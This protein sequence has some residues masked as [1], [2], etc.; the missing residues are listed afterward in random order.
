MRS[1]S[2]SIVFCCIFLC[3]SIVIAQD[4]TA[5]VEIPP[6]T[7]TTPFP[8]TSSDVSPPQQDTLPIPISFTIRGGSALGAYEAGYMYMLTETIKRNRKLF[9]PEIVT[10]ASA[11]T[12]NAILTILALGTAPQDDPQK[13]L[14]YKVWTKLGYEELLDAT[15]DRTPPGA[16]SSRSLLWRLSEMIKEEW[17]KGL[18][19]DFSITVGASTTRLLATNLEITK[20]LSIP[21]QISQFVFRVEGQGPGKPPRLTNQLWAKPSLDQLILPFSEAGNNNGQNYEVM[22]KVAFASCGIPVV[23]PPQWVDYCTVKVNENIDQRTSLEC[24][25]GLNTVADRF[26][27]GGVVDN[28]PI[29]LAY[30]LSLNKPEKE[31]LGKIE[32][33]LSS[34]ETTSKTDKTLFLYLDPDHPSYPSNDKHSSHQILDK[35]TPRYTMKGTE[36]F[37][38][39]PKFLSGFVGSVNASELYSLLQGDPQIRKRVKLTN[40]FY[41]P[42]ASVWDGK[43]GFMDKE[44]MKYDFYL[45]MHDAQNFIQK[46]VT[47]YL[48]TISKFKD[49]NNGKINLLSD[50]LAK[51]NNKSWKPYRCMRA[52]F[53][54]EG[55]KEQSC[56]IKQEI[57]HDAPSEKERIATSPPNVRDFKILMQTTVDRL[58]NHCSLLRGKGRK[59]EVISSGHKLC[60]KAYNQDPPEHV[61]GVKTFSGKGKEDDEWYKCIAKRKAKHR[62]EKNRAVRFCNHH[63]DNES[64]YEYVLRL[65]ARYEFGFKDLDLD[66]GRGDRAAAKIQSVFWKLLTD[67]DD[68]HNSTVQTLGKPAVTFLT[69][70]PPRNIFYVMVGKVLMFGWS[71]SPSGW[72]RFN[73]NILQIK[74]AQT[75]LSS[76]NAVA[77]FSSAVGIEYQPPWLS[78]P[79]F[80]TTAGARLG[81]QF[82]TKINFDRNS[83]NNEVGDKTLNCSSPIIQ[84]FLSASIFSRIRFEIGLEFF[85][86]IRD[87]KYTMS[88]FEYTYI[89]TVGY[90]FLPSF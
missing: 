62:K 41:Q 45:G 71:R 90:Q 18:S 58:Y 4:A 26:V 35:P 68:P 31:D 83:C 29:N 63:R 50:N 32:Q 88:E 44:F 30:L 28:S 74:G 7:S 60:L 89:A 61:P 1:G 70:V 42:I 78:F 81:Y 37:K 25:Y 43:F 47:N 77:T 82:S 38:T 48:E 20:D 56:N 23:F 53:D 59:E 36:L 5:E 86:S 51:T 21:N 22:M 13:S 64:Q 40:N 6:S 24:K 9:K 69:Y 33:R 87:W 16:L 8:K 27:D 14:Y 66:P 3:H 73:W 85:P 76:E 84:G 34:I 10:G 57:S 80:Q 79:L 49:I 19:N 39:L 12:I 72:F 75:W 46:H 17:N 67:F 11:G 65:L 15:S 2:F 55:N 54:G 52:V